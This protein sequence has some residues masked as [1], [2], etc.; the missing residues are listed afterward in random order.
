[1]TACLVVRLSIM[2]AVVFWTLAGWF[3][4]NQYG[5]LAISDK[6]AANLAWLGFFFFL[7]GR[8]SGAALLQRVSPI[9]F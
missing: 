9:R 2:I 5:I 1:M 4:A 3:R 8:F 7:A 6:G